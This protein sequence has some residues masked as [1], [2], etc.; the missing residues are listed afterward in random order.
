M[1]LVARDR[2]RSNVLYRRSYRADRGPSCYPSDSIYGGEVI[3]G[4]PA[5][6]ALF[7]RLNRADGDLGVIIVLDGDSVILAPGLRGDAVPLDDAETTRLFE[8]LAALSRLPQGRVG[9]VL[10][11]TFHRL[12][13]GRVTEQGSCDPD[14]FDLA[15]QALAL[16]DELSGYAPRVLV[17]VCGRRT[18][19]PVVEGRDVITV[20]IGPFRNGADYVLPNAAAL[21]RFFTFLDD[22]LLGHGRSPGSKGML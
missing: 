7:R 21:A 17:Y 8:R 14:R 2:Q 4:R 12:D 18:T 11:D 3:V 9:L 10:N 19:L 1:P 5:L 20:R 6:R 16:A 13:D 22:E 15:S